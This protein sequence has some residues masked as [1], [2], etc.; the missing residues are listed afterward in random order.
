MT[1]KYIID[2]RNYAGV[3]L[4]KSAFYKN[5][6]IAPCELNGSRNNNNVYDACDLRI[7][8]A[9]LLTAANKLEAGTLFEE[10]FDWDT[11]ESGMAFNFKSGGGICWYIGDDFEDSDLVVL[12]F[13]A[14]CTECRNYGKEE[15]TRAPERDIKKD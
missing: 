10:E 1:D 6:T 4:E 2:T 5:V 14:D 12:A 11:V 15:L 7:L 13:Q 9:E 8:S 3:M